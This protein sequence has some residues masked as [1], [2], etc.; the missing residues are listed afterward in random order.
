MSVDPN[1][2]LARL[3]DRIWKLECE[4]EAESRGRSKDVWVLPAGLV[5]VFLSGFRWFRDLF[6]WF[7]THLAD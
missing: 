3:E 1:E 2:R 6:W 5:V 7:A 4:L